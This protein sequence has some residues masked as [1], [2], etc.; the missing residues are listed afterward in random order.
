MERR[1]DGGE[2]C[3]SL[4]PLPPPGGGPVEPRRRRPEREGSPSAAAGLGG[5]SRRWAPALS[6]QA[7]A[8]TASLL[9]A[10]RHLRARPLQPLGPAPPSPGYCG[11]WSVREPRRPTA[12]LRRQAR[13][14]RRGPG[15]R[16]RC[17]RVIA[18]A[19]AATAGQWE[20]WE[21]QTHPPDWLPRGLALVTPGRGPRGSLYA[22]RDGRAGRAVGATGGGGCAPLCGSYPAQCR[23]STPLRALASSPS[24]L[25]G[26]NGQRHSF[27]Q[28]SH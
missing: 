2:G 26:D 5:R 28:R 24:G 7:A 16:W 20:G 15:G 21:K 10:D 23:G 1:R 9:P 11:G 6:S 18:A 12:E 14:Q 13:A 25:L 19:V 3:A 4:P 17:R 22:S 8:A 27:P